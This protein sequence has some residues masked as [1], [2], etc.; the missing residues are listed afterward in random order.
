MSWAVNPAQQRG[1]E[2]VTIRLWKH[3]WADGLMKTQ[4]KSSW[5]SPE[6]LNGGFGGPQDL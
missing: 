1:S 4:G 2:W 5:R 3:D 6:L